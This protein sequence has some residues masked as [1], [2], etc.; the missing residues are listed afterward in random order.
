MKKLIAF[1]LCTVMCLSLVAC[2]S[3]EEAENTKSA[4]ETTEKVTATETE[5]VTEAET[6]GATE[7]ETEEVTDDAPSANETAAITFLT[8]SS[9]IPKLSSD[10]N[11]IKDTLVFNSDNTVKFGKNN[12]TWELTFANAFTAEAMISKD[13]APAYKAYLYKDTGSGTYISLTAVTEGSSSTKKVGTFLKSSEYTK[14]D[15]NETNWKDYFEF[16]EYTEV[17]KNAFDEVT[18]LYIRRYLFLKEELGVVCTDLSNF[19]FEYSS[20][21]GYV[22]ATADPQSGNYTLGALQND[23]DNNTSSSNESM[24]LFQ[25]YDAEGNFEGRYGVH[26]TSFEINE[27]PEDNIY[28]YDSDF[29]ITRV[30]GSIYVYNKT[31]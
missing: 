29:N 20:K 22:T 15:V 3:S 16:D 14:I 28:I 31:K 18:H 9:W 27:F 6:E 25:S 30:T 21:Y 1:I 12:L 24:H 2:S 17:N 19:D 13:G 4:A 26:I 5:E 10:E 7:A 11:A 23:T 8:E